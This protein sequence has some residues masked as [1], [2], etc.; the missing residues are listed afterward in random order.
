M[1]KILTIFK[2][3]KIKS[4]IGLI[5]YWPILNE[6]KFDSL[7]GHVHENTLSN[8]FSGKSNIQSIQ[9]MFTSD[10]FDNINSA[11]CPNGFNLTLQPG[12]YFSNGSFTFSLWIK[13]KKF[14]SNAK[15]IHVF[16]L[17]ND[18]SNTHV[19]SVQIWQTNE[20]KPCMEIQ[21]INEESHK[22]QANM[23]FEL[24]VWQFFTVTLNE[25]N[26]KIYLNGSLISE[27]NDQFRPINISR[28]YA[29]LGLNSDS[30]YDEIRIYN[31][32]LTNEEISI[33][34][35]TS[36][37]INLQYKDYF[38]KKR[39]VLLSQSAK[40]SEDEGFLNRNSLF[41]FLCIIF[42]NFLTFLHKLFF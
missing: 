8:D 42:Q 15:I 26:L 20:G 3:Y 22:T 36:D 14:D 31:R 16:N 39:S 21:Q 12:V 28:K 11:I 24:N 25:T 10:R 17:K 23:G 29:Y 30:S 33:L 7:T 41:D 40:V 2:R 34:M 27:D 5:N 9:S 35:N 6:Q 19:D 13:F 38:L 4:S 32:P 1:N 18:S 37:A